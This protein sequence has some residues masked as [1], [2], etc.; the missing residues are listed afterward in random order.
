MTTL[1]IISIVGGIIVMIRFI[2]DGYKSV[3]KPSAIQDTE[4]ALLKD[5][6]S[7]MS[8]ELSSIKENHLAHIEKNISD[9]QIGQTKIFTIL[10]ERLPQKKK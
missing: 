8:T 4:I 7:I 3:F 5:K 10:Q 6:F 1:E 9:L 2:I